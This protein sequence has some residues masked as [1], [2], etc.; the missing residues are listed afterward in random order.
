MFNYFYTNVGID[1]DSRAKRIIN[2][3]SNLCDCY[4]LTSSCKFTNKYPFKVYTGM[5]LKAKLIYS[6]FV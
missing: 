3:F 5:F 4:V 6:P 1:N 2:T